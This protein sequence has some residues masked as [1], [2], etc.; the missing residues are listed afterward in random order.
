[1]SIIPCVIHETAAGGY[2]TTLEDERF[3]HREI[4]LQGPISRPVAMD[5]IRQLR[6]LAQ[7]GKADITMLISS[8]GGDIVSGLA[9]YDT[10]QSL[11]CDIR[12]VCVGEASSMAAILFAAGTK[13]KRAILPNATVLIHDPILTDASGPALSVEALT[14]RLMNIRKQIAEIL[15]KHTGAHVD[16]ILKLTARDS[17]FNAEEAIRFGLA[18]Y[19][20]REWGEDFEAG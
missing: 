20:I 13:G 3:A 15:S 10:M 1:M 7:E 5:V 11:K 19:V 14:I 18:D 9:V 6:Y 4:E 16:E 2:R 8:P 17:Y 12:T